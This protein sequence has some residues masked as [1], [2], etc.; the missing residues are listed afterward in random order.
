MHPTLEQ[1]LEKFRAWRTNAARVQ[2]AWELAVA[3]A[4]QKSVTV[5][6]DGVVHSVESD[7]ERT[8]V[9]VGQDNNL[10][11]MYLTERCTLQALIMGSEDAAA[12][13]EVDSMI[14]IAFPTGEQCFV[15]FYHPL[16]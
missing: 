4:N 13:A 8:L 15:T 5:Q 11:R 3:G 2:V 7:G 16:S 10:V 14:R 12:I 6:V 1:V 9:I